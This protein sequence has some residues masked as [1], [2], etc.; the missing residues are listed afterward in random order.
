[1]P[2]EPIDLLDDRFNEGMER[3][4]HL[5]LIVAAVGRQ[6]DPPHLAFGVPVLAGCLQRLTA[7]IGRSRR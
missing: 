1:M 3:L 6:V 5:N 2:V 7:G 4:E